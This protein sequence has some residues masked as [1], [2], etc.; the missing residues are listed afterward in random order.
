MEPFGEA[1]MDG[2]EIVLS[3]PSGAG[4][5]RRF[6]IVDCGHVAGDDYHCCLYKSCCGE[7][8]DTA[9]QSAQLKAK[10]TPIATTIARS[11]GRTSISFGARGVLGEE[12]CYLAIAD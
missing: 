11:R 12:E 7:T 5:T 3:P 6:R 2:E 1:A 4:G 10:I 9:P 8:D